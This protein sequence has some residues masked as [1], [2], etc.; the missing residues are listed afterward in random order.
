MK[1]IFN[2][3][4]NV[5]IVELEE[6]ENKTILNTDDIVEAREYFIKHMTTLFNNAVK[7]N[8][9]EVNV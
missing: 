9:K 5:Y 3:I 1:V 6:F 7:E 8:L 4:E 2:N